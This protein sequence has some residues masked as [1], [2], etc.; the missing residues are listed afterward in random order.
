MANDWASLPIDY[1]LYLPE[2]WANDAARRTR[3][4][5]PDDV[6]FQTKPQIAL[7]QIRAAFEAG[8]PTQ[9][10]TSAAM[11]RMLTQRN[12]NGSTSFSRPAAGHGG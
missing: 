8:V 9:G 5:I 3:A 11:T 10:R 4:G 2:T 1:R 7:G 12:K 6:S